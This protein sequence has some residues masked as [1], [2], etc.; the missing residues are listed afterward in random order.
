MEDLILRHAA[1][2]RHIS[3]NATPYQQIDDFNTGKPFDLPLLETL[4]LDDFQFDF[5]TLKRFELCP[6]L[7]RLELGTMDEMDPKQL[8]ELIE[9]PGFE[10]LKEIM[11]SSDW[12][13]PYEDVNFDTLELVCYT[14]KIA[15]ER[16]RPDT[17]DEED[18]EDDMSFDGDEPDQEFWDEGF[19]EDED[20]EATDEEFD[21]DDSETEYI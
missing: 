21:E 17:S 1:T 7:M 16:D 18:Y 3:L 20:E 2:L 19:S 6:K 13:A 14:K 5:D 4:A 9:R 15:L 11:L 10:A 12:P 8:T